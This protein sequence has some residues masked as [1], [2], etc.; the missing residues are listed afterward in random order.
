M[1]TFSVSSSALTGLTNDE[2]EAPTTKMPIVFNGL[3]FITI[4]S[5]RQRPSLLRVFCYRSLAS[6]RIKAHR[7][8]YREDLLQTLIKAEFIDGGT[9]AEGAGIGGQIDQLI[10]I[11]IRV[12][13]FFAGAGE[14]AKLR[15]FA[16]ISS[17]CGVRMRVPP[18]KPTSPQPTASHMSRITLGLSCA[19][20]KDADAR[21]ISE[22]KMP[23][24][25]CIVFYRCK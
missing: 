1:K 9:S 14:R 23:G 10:G 11:L 3:D 5:A 8:V 19:S 24:V 21:R 17:R 2:I 18:S 4:Q 12:I 22:N 7:A 6:E 13:E 20:A 16:A 15:P 25:R